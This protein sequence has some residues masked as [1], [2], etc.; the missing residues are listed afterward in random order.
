L[1][2][3][4]TAQPSSSHGAL[5]AYR[6]FLADIRQRA[7]KAE[8]AAPVEQDRLTSEICDCLAAGAYLVRAMHYT[9]LGLTGDPASGIG[10][11]AVLAQRAK[12]LA[13]GA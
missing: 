8:K 6:T 2:L 1:P 5:V 10:G 3:S 13:G 9:L 12:E 11:G 7:D 4:H